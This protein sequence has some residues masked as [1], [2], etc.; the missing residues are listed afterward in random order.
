[1]PQQCNFAITVK[2][3]IWY[4]FRKKFN[5]S[6]IVL[7]LSTLVK[8]KTKMFCVEIVFIYPTR[9]WVEKK[10]SM[11]LSIGVSICQSKDKTL[12]RYGW[13]LMVETSNLICLVKCGTWRYLQRN[14]CMFATVQSELSD[15]QLI[16]CAD[17]YWMSCFLEQ[18][19][20]GSADCY[21]SCS[22]G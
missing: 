9:N 3:E 18:K 8:L 22:C 6:L 14:H 15:K 20:S 5:V 21:C 19:N 2:P 1:M 7:K 11:K 13:P 12:E 10:L 4:R 17:S 16:T